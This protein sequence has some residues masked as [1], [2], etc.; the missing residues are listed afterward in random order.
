MA[1]KTISDS[2]IGNLGKMCSIRVVSVPNVTG[3]EADFRP[4]NI[5]V[6]ELNYMPN[7]I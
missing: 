7:Y 1:Y 6:K 5:A 4:V 3:L 2:V